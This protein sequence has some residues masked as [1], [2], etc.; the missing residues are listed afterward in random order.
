M[1]LKTCTV[2]TNRLKFLNCLFPVSHLELCNLPK[3]GL[4]SVSVIHFE[5]I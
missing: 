1:A 4:E 2:P 3:E 5:R